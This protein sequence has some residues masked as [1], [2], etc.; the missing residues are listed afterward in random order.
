MFL[1]ALAQVVLSFLAM[2][3]AD[4]HTIMLIRRLF[5]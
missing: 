1:A 3:K 2:G 4:P 5:I